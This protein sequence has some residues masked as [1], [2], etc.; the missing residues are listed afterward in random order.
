MWTLGIETTSAQG[1]VALLRGD[2]VERWAA[3]EPPY[4]SG[5]FAAVE[6]VLK[7]AGIGLGDIELFAVADG[8]GSFTGVRIGLTAVKGWIEVLGKPAAGVSTLQAVAGGAPGLAGLDAGR[9]EV[10]FG[11][12][13]GGSS[14]EGLEAL[15]AFCRRAAAWRGPVLTPQA[16][17]AAACPQAKLVEPRLAANVGRLGIAAWRRGERKD[18]LSLD[19]RYLRRSDAELPLAG[20]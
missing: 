20:R 14:E 6:A 9:G 19:A 17:I 3:L 16:A 10:Y 11:A 8:P 18:A 7:E 4:S 5:L 15:E 2:G 12:Y 13:A 1:S